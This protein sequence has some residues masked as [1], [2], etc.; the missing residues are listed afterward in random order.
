[1]GNPKDQRMTKAAGIVETGVHETLACYGF[2][3]EHWRRIR[4]TIRWSAS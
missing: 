4:T 3:E 1:V 2:P